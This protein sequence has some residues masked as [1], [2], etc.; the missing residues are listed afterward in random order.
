MAAKIDIVRA[1]ALNGVAHG[2]L[3]RTG[4]V[5]TGLFESLN[6]GL[7]SDDVKADVDIN[8]RRAVEAVAPDSTLV[9]LHQV[10]S[11][12]AI[13]VT[14]GFPDDDRPEADAMVTDRPGLALGI[15]TADCAPILLADREAGVI[16]AAHAGWKGAMTGVAKSVVEAMEELGAERSRIAAAIGPCIGRGSYEVD[17]DFRKRFEAI[18]PEN[19]QYFRDGA[20]G[21]HYFDLEAYVAAWLAFSSVDTVETL[22]LDTYVNEDRFF[23]YRRA[24]HRDEPDYGR[25]L[26]VIAL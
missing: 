6:V 18:E 5:S 16:G 7:G 2:F 23:S 12:D 9:T 15:L 3:G 11:P 13:R 20:P 17:D 14:H 25:Q 26:S 10:H 4:G 22:G 21:H 8:R 24:T 1:D 19:E